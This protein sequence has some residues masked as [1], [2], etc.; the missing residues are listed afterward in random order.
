MANTKK[1]VPATPKPTITPTAN[2]T[3][4]NIAGTASG[5]IP[6]D[7]NGTNVPQVEAQLKKENAA[8]Y[9]FWMQPDLKPIFESAVKDGTLVSLQTGSAAA[10]QKFSEALQP[11][12]QVHGSNMLAMQTDQAAY[13]T[14]PNSKYGQTLANREKEVQDAATKIGYN[15]LDPATIA[16]IAETTFNT[17]YLD[18]TFASPAGQD[19]LATTIANTA[20]AQ[21][22][23]LTG[24][25]GADV[26]SSLIDYN[27]QMGNPY[28]S[29][30][31]DS[32]VASIEDPSKGVD[33]NTYKTMIKTAAA[34]KYSGYADQINK[35]VT[36]QQIADPYISTMTNLLELPYDS[37]NYSQYLNDPLIQKGMAATVNPDG[38][39]QPMTNW[40]F[41]DSVRSDPR[42]AYTNNA[43]DSV[44]TMLHQIGKDFG[45][46]S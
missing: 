8:I 30:W 25:A 32:A 44:N 9:A 29:A 4:A 35:G 21:K 6:A 28:S 43:R 14:G 38:T 2:N 12:I 46:V 10:A 7:L 19:R 20:A 15:N 41:A 31:I 16:K 36:V 5:I 33:P 45:F 26:R 18:T 34:T 27:N 37:S 23:Q 13:G 3:P 42:W 24:G 11:W 40:Q 17:D 1:K 39:T 22:I